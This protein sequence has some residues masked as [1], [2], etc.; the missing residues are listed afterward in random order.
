MEGKNLLNKIKQE[1]QNE[2]QF[3]KFDR[4]FERKHQFKTIVLGDS[5]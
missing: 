5:D 2:S 4:E 3:D 1:V